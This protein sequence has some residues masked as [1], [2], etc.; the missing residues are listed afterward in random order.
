MSNSEKPSGNAIEEAVINLRYK[1]IGEAAYKRF[2]KAMASLKRKG[3]QKKTVTID[4][5]VNSGGLLRLKNQLDSLAKNIKLSAGVDVTSPAKGRKNPAAELHKSEV[6]AAGRRKPIPINWPGRE[7]SYAPREFVGPPRPR[8]AESSSPSVMITAEQIKRLGDAAR[9]AA[10]AVS[11]EGKVLAARTAGAREFNGFNA[12]AREIRNRLDPFGGDHNADIFHRNRQL[13]ELGFNPAAPDLSRMRF[14]P[15]GVRGGPGGSV[16]RPDMTAFKSA[17]A[18]LERWAK[19]A[20]GKIQQALNIEPRVKTGGMK[21]SLRN[22]MG[23]L[24]VG[25]AFGGFASVMNEAQQIQDQIKNLSP[26]IEDATRAQQGLLAAAKQTNASYKGTVDIYSSLAAISDKTKLSTDQNVGITKTI[27]MA[28]QLGGGSAEGQKRAI[29]QLEQALQMGKMDGQGINSI[30]AQSRGLA[31]VL[32]QGMGKS[33]ADLKQLTKEGKIT[34]DEI[35]KAFMKM[36]PEVEKR[37][38]K[39]RV[40]LGG[41]KNYAKTVML[42]WA[43]RLS[44]AWDGW[45]KGMGFIRDVM[46]GLNSF[47]ARAF[48]GL[49][50]ALGGGEN[51]AKAVQYA[52]LALGGGAVLAAIATFGGAVLAALWPVALAAGAVFAAIL[53]VDDVMGWVAGKKSVMGDLVGPF[54]D[55]KPVLDEISKSFGEL[56]KAWASLWDGGLGD[57]LNKEDADPP[58]ARSFRK[59]LE[60]VNETIQSLK[61]LVGMLEALKNGDYGGAMEIAGKKFRNF[62]AEGKAGGLSALYNASSYLVPSID[63]TTVVA[64]KL[65]DL[66]PP[67][68]PSRQDLQQQLMQQPPSQQTIN[69]S[70]IINIGATSPDPDAIGRSAADAVMNALKAPMLPT[71]ERGPR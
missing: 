20:G 14:S 11:S 58:M 61:D 8:D 22:A 35:T 59:V 29:V 45:G 10:E 13:S 21:S 51:A 26:S 41:L 55:F 47:M 42:E 12:S 16:P 71:S 53:A 1:L 49:S 32:A 66:A 39:V 57:A 63:P 48:D 38:A 18:S 70:P 25:F 56:G 4:V 60:A 46:E 69:N 30:E 5:K 65:A 50:A 43:T 6:E 3:D 64:A 36:G 44:G 24:G 34:A 19:S 68:V 9:A 28:S 54:E 17:I 52:F 33:M 67:S 37:F 27:Q 2:D 40:T 62:V 15:L 31:I 7:R 23:Q